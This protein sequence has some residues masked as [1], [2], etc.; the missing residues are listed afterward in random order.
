MV[1]VGSIVSGGFRL[2]RERPLSVLIWGAVYMVFGAVGSLV[3]MR[4]FM[5][6][7]Q[8]GGTTP[9]ELPSAAMFGVLILFYLGYLLLALV[10]YAAAIRAALRPEEDSFASMRVGMDELRLLGVIVL[11][12]VISLVTLIAGSIVAAITG[13]IFAVIAQASG[14]GAAFIGVF[15]SILAVYCLAIF[16]QVRL[17]PAIP[18]TIMRRQVVITEAWRLSRGRFWT[19][20]GGYFVLALIM[21]IALLVVVAFTMGPYM[22]ELAQHGFTP[23][24]VQA[25]SQA[26]M[27]RQLGGIGIMTVV[28]WILGGLVGGAGFAVWG[29]AL[30]AVADGLVGATDVDYAATFE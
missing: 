19:L 25:A 30:A 3:L 2:L 13:M 8:A 27:Q 22:A 28:G 21:L 6:A 4:P 17:S 1:T 18:L 26:Q 7:A 20:F 24:A 5:A 12:M 11:L 14:S 23:E 10:L 29:G 9:G 16:V 15:V